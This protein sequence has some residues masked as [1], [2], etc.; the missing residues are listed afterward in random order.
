[1]A[2][3][4]LFIGCLVGAMAGIIPYGFVLFSGMG[5][6]LMAWRQEGGFDVIMVMLGLL[7]GSLFGNMASVIPYGVTVFIAIILAVMVWR[8]EGSGDSQSGPTSTFT[9]ILFLFVS[10]GLLWSGTY[11]DFCNPMLGASNVC[12]SP[13]SAGY[14]T[15]YMGC[16]HDCAITG[17]SFFANSP[18]TFLL[19]GNII[20]FIQSFFAAGAQSPIPFF[21]SLA[22]IAI[23]AVLLFM[24]LGLNG[25][26]EVLGSGVSLGENDT[27]TRLMQSLGIG[28][29]LW[30]FITSPI[31]GLESFFTYIGF[32][33]GGAIGSGILYIMFTIIYTFELYRQ[34]KSYSA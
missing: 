13:P 29:L 5:M 33:L 21:G 27:G 3:V 31:I 14:I 32:G 23:G 15:A 18:F 12:L 20:G 24:G 2:L 17:F 30:G 16:V 34:A 19:N 1:M 6:A 10:V 9:L 28:L 22:S 4:G 25:S 7:V 11:I 26:A 8:T